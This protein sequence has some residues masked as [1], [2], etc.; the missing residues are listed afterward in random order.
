MR[1]LDT[2]AV[3]SCIGM[4]SMNELN[5]S[6]MM[7]DADKAEKYLG[8]FSQ[9]SDNK[10]LGIIQK[11]TKPLMESAHVDE[12]IVRKDY[13]TNVSTG[14]E[15]AAREYTKHANRYNLLPADVK[16]M[17]DPI[18]SQY[19]ALESELSNIGTGKRSKEYK[20]VE[21][22]KN[23]AQHA[24]ESVLFTHLANLQN[25]QMSRGM[26]GASTPGMESYTYQ[27]AIFYPKLEAMT[28]WVNITPLLISQLYL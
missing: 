28:Q 17:I 15:K 25:R 23:Q 16:R 8:H 10:C 11:Y 20:I 26:F 27:D 18:R 6:F 22:K 1:Y 21:Y 19:L 24:M 3:T 13:W 14:L 4:E 12:A 7:S 2:A 9:E 5:G